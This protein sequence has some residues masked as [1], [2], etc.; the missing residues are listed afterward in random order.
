MMRTHDQKWLI[1]NALFSCCDEGCRQEQSFHYGELAISPVGEVVCETCWGWN[2]AGE[3]DAP[4]WFD[5]PKFNPFGI[6]QEAEI[7]RLKAEAQTAWEAGRDAAAEE[8][9]EQMALSDEEHIIVAAIRAL[10]RP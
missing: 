10:K 9:H 3:E 2:N 5:L 1:E 8:I 6:D 7:T 4:R